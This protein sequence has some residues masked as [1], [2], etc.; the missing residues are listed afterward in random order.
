MCG[1]LYILNGTGFYELS[2]ETQKLLRIFSFEIAVR[3]FHVC[4][5]DFNLYGSVLEFQIYKYVV[6][7]NEPCPFVLKFL[8]SF[9]KFGRNFCIISP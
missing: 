5:K 6:L 1:C 9:V 2:E 4:I 8:N 3:I 7:S